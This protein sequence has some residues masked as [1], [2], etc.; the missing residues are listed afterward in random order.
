MSGVKPELMT[1]PEPVRLAQ[2]GRTMNIASCQ[3]DVVSGGLVQAV[4][5]PGYRC[6]AAYYSSGSWQAS[7][8]WHLLPYIAQFSSL[9][10]QTEDLGLE[11]LVDRDT[12]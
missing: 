10:H 7:V 4:C 8:N 1:V 11:C 12:V 3:R 6:R 9:R 5:C 2:A